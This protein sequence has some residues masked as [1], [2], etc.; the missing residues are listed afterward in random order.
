MKKLAIAVLVIFVLAGCA[1]TKFR[2]KDVRKV[3]TGMPKEEV[4]HLI[5]K[6]TSV[7]ITPDG[8]RYIWVYVNGMTGASRSLWID[9]KD[10]KVVKAPPIP[11]EFQ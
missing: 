6:P 11:D 7:S 3:Q 1:G 8:V 4:V 2:W 9:F 10:G 5:G